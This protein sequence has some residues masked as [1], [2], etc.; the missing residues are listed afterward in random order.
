VRRGDLYWAELPEPYG[1]RPVLVVSRSAGL[2]V[3]TRVTVAP[4][5][6][7][8]RGIASEV[9]VG[10]RQ[11][12]RAGSVVTCDNLQTLLRDRL[13]ERPIGRLS[14]PKTIELDAALRFALGIRS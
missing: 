14:V 5:T 8:E 9:R 7:T 1:R 2:G 10:T 4:V 6:S 12:V 11:G 13:D 3:R